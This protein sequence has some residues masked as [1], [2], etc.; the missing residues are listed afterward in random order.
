MGLQT[1]KDW[2]ILAEYWHPREIVK[3][4]GKAY[5]I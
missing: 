2:I 1:L 5:D 3:R 4:G